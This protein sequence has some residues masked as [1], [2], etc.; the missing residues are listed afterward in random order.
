MSFL[1]EYDA[2]SPEQQVPVL[3]TWVRTSA[4][5]FATVKSGGLVTT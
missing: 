5:E 1:E 2:A 4:H 3:M